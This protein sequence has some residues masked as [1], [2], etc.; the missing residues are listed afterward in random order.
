[1]TEPRICV[2]KSLPP[3]LVVAA[4]LRA[5]VAHPDNVPEIHPH[6]LGGLHPVEIASV[7]SKRWRPGSILT[8]GFLGGSP[9]TQGR[10]LAH[11]RRWSEVCNIGFARHE[12]DLS[13]IRIAFLAGQ[14]SWS[15]IGTD[16]LSIPAPEPTMNLGWIDD[17]TPDEEV[18]RVVVHETGHTLSF[19]HEAQL[20]EALG[21]LVFDRDRVYA[22][23]GG[24]PNFWSRDQ[25][26]SQ[27]LTP[28]ELAGVEHSDFDKR[29]IM[30]YWFDPSWIVPP[31]L[32]PATTD[33][34]PTDIARAASWYPRPEA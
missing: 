3:S 22:Y 2:P 32:I 23:F 17:D 24:A 33:L 21:Q 11:M 18:R 19:E 30:E 7:T 15:Y 31:T 28:L 4:A 29:S 6:L 8:V 14:G 25:V 9:A 13:Q 20:G 34:S 10:V 16:I 26:D 5:H 1:V 12:P 27:I